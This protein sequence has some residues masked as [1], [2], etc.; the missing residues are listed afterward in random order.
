M[1]LTR[2]QRGRVGSLKGWP[3]RIHP[4]RQDVETAAY[5]VFNERK[6]LHQQSL[7]YFDIGEQ[8]IQV[9]GLVSVDPSAFFYVASTI[10]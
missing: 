1:V 10:L 4:S 9:L 5:Y 3:R 7:R 2:A 8:S 6:G